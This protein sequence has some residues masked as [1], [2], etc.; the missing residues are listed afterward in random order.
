MK[1]KWQHIDLVDST[2]IFEIVLND[3][4]LYNGPNYH[5]ALQVYHYYSA[6]L[7]WF[8]KLQLFTIESDST[9]VLVS[10]ITGGI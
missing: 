10:T 5:D 8:D 7:E 2:N 9:R 4:V 6:N 3:S 1:H